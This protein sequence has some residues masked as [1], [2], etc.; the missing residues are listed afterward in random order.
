MLI[1][2]RIKLTPLDATTS[3]A[4]DETKVIFLS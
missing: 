2:K 3:L 1:G 4:P